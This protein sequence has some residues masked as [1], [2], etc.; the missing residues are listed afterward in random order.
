MTYVSEAP[1]A[2]L[3]RPT[4]EEIPEPPLERPAI[5]GKFIFCGDSKFLVRGVTYGGFR[6]RPNGEEFPEPEVVESDFEQM[7]ANGINAIRTYTLPPLWLLD[8]AQKSGIKVMAG[9]AWEEHVAF[10]DDASLEERICK[11]LRKE[12]RA[13]AGHPA[14]LCYS[15]GNEIP[16]P[17]VR[18]HGRQ[19]IESF[20]RRLYGIAK[21][22]DPSGLVTYVNY[23]TTEYL[24]LPFLDLICFNVFLESQESL[25]KYLARLQNIAG[26]RPLLL[27]EIGLDSRRNGVQVQARSLDRQVRTA[28]SSGC[29]GAF[30]FSWTDEW[31]RGGAD[32]EDWDFGL[33][34]RC[35]SPK[36]ALER[37][38]DAFNEAPLSTDDTWPRVSVVVCIYNGERTIR[39][40]L[41]GLCSLEYPNYEVIVVDDGSKDTTLAIV[42]EFDVRIISTENHGLSS[43]RNTGLHA[44]TGDI[45]AYIDSDA[46]PDPHWLT[47]LAST[48]RTGRFAAVGGPN[49]AP[50][51]DGAI[52]RCV[53]NSPGGPAHVLL[54]DDVAEHIPGCNMAFLKSALE[55]IGGFDPQFRIAGD[56]V[57]VCW[58]I[59][60]K[61]WKIGFSPAAVVW[62]HCRNSIKTFWKQ[63][64]NYGRAEAFLERKWPEKYNS[65]GDMTWSGRLYGIFRGSPFFP[66]G[67]RVYYGVWGSGLFQSIYEPAPSTMWSLP[68]MPEWYL[69]VGFLGVLS[70]F[71]FL[72]SRLAIA[73]P[74]CILAFGAVIL[75]VSHDLKGT[76]ISMTRPRTFSTV[77]SG[78]LTF[79]LHLMQPLARLVGRLSAC[80]PAWHPRQETTY[81]LPIPES[82]RLWSESWHDLHTWIFRLQQSLTRHGVAH[83]PGRETSRWDLELRKGS[84]G[85]I[86]IR[87]VIEEHG[88]GR[89][90]IRVRCWPRCFPPWLMFVLLFASLSVLAALDH[91]WIASSLL[92]IIGVVLGMPVLRDCGN[93]MGGLRSALNELGTERC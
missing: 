16:S 14:I 79:F 21:S 10:L 8:A 69:M 76:R 60:K 4:C 51:T 67:W 42:R 83:L 17:I 90:L 13:C 28:F 33:T 3:P 64:V 45:V 36:P 56:D 86:R 43:A 24:Q 23:P 7:R 19:R 27:S 55:E 52:A 49:I 68:L 32:I 88:R 15:I 22:E 34:T 62:H 63:Q 38:R 77:C 87:C 57:D 6:P 91:S 61:G 58:R 9:L 35:R 82:H 39:D 41:E 93:A 89:Q 12:I 48:F 47:F 37:V 66:W 44:A 1:V 78:M 80:L 40:C 81:A 85:V 29:A 65:F 11:R 18:W 59:Q 72:W 74:L 2:E 84:L 26:N 50:D 46:R 53:S 71:S 92:G 5:R 75:R 31:H 54:S 30:V 25:A 73:L 70:V 20:L